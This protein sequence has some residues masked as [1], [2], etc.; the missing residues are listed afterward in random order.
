MRW[1]GRWGLLVAGSVVLMVGAVMLI[2]TQA[3]STPVERDLG[4]PAPGS[5]GGLGVAIALIAIG[6]LAILA[7]FTVRYG[8]RR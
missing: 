6:L 4:A 2:V 1:L 5:D 3:R 7:W 8:R